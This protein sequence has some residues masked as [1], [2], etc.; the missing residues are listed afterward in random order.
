MKAKGVQI[1]EV[2]D[3]REFQ[4]R[5]EPVWKFLD[6]HPGQGPRGL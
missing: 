3:I 1:N 6:R 4:D 5:A 2:K